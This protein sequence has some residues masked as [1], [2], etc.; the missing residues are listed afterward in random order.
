MAAPTPDAHPEPKADPKPNPH[1]I[2]G[3]P[4]APVIV[5]P[6]PLIVGPHPWLVPSPLLLQAPGV[7][8]V[9]G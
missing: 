6:H 2:L 1:V 5:G 8:H 3:P 4:V 9:V 7:V